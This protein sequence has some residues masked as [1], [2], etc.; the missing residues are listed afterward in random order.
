[1]EK[2]CCS[3]NIVALIMEPYYLL[4]IRYLFVTQTIVKGDN[5]YVMYENDESH[6]WQSNLANATMAT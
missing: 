5:K 4:E 2:A 3:K 1:M 6:A